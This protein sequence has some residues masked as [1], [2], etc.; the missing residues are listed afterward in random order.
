VVI[1]VGWSREDGAFQEI[2]HYTG[3]LNWRKSVRHFGKCL[4][5]TFNHYEYCCRRR[6]CGMGQTG[7]GKGRLP[8]TR[9]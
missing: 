2:Q 1:G 5:D 7:R 8:L 3:A 9:V 6:S 4:T